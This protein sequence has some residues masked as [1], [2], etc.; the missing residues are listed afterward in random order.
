VISA[1]NF[2]SIALP[3]TVLAVV[4]VTGCAGGQAGAVDSA[5]WEPPG[6]GQ[7][8]GPGLNGGAPQGAPAA[9]HR[10]A[11]GTG[12]PEQ[13]AEQ[14]SEQFSAGS[15]RVDSAERVSDQRQNIVAR[16]TNEYLLGRSNIS[17]L[18]VRAADEGPRRSAAHAVVNDNGVAVN[19]A[20][21]VELKQGTWRVTNAMTLN[22]GD[23]Q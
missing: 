7:S 20:L 1:I 8:I 11:L 6:V 3:G 16:A 23:L 13:A 9:V 5:A 15:D 21:T 17:V 19:L 4:L 18:S 10:Q 14:P 22:M 2:R 12:G